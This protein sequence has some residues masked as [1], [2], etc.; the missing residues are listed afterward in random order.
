V[1]NDIRSRAR[2]GAAHYKTLFEAEKDDI[3]LENTYSFDVKA[4]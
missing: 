2:E 4:E 1:Q 3:D